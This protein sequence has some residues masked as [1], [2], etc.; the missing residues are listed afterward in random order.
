MK[1]LYKRAE[2]NPKYNAKLYLYDR[3]YKN[4]DF[5]EEII[6]FASETF[7]PERILSIVKRIYKEYRNDLL[8]EICIDENEI[9]DAIITNTTQEY[10]DINEFIYYQ[11]DCYDY[12]QI[13]KIFANIISEVVSMINSYINKASFSNELIQEYAKM[14]IDELYNKFAISKEDIS[15]LLET[16]NMEHI[17]IIS[18]SNLPN[19]LDIKR[20]FNNYVNDDIENYIKEKIV[21]PKLEQLFNQEKYIDNTMEN[22]IDYSKLG[23][24]RILN[25]MY[26]DAKKMR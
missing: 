18:S 20:S 11:F 17:N 5:C 2:R 22:G 15:N 21:T 25:R 7:P 3:L 26:R 12:V 9:K 6:N 14:Y 10:E 24:N 8:N 19:K 23:K 16:I 1:R 13:D 4:N